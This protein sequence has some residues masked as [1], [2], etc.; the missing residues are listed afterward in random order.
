MPT[1]SLYHQISQPRETY[2]DGYGTTR[3]VWEPQA[4]TVARKIYKGL[5]RFF[6]GP[7][8]IIGGSG[9]IELLMGPIATDIEKLKKLQSIY[10]TAA[11]ESKRLRLPLS[12]EGKNAAKEISRLETKLQFVKDDLSSSKELKTIFDTENNEALNDFLFNSNSYLLQNVGKWKK[13]HYKELQKTMPKSEAFK[14]TFLETRQDLLEA[15]GIKTKIENG[16]LKRIK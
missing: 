1:K 16:I 12:V 14:Q 6:N 8:N 11:A 15:L 2:T 5:N 4:V 13:E 3:E 9:S 7:E 10:R